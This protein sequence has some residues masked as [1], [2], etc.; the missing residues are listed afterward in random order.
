MD[1]L[2]YRENDRF[3]PIPEN[4]KNLPFVIAKHFIDI[5]V[6]PDGIN[7]LE[8][9]CFDRNGDLFICNTPQG[10]IYKLNVKTK[11][12]KLF[13]ELPNHM[14]P[15]AIKIHK[16]GRI[17][18]T[19]AGSDNGCLILILSE[20]G[21]ILDEIIT[22]TNKMI[23]D[24]VFDTDGGFY[25]TDLGGTMSNKT[26]GVFYVSPDYKSV[27]P[28]IE[29]GMIASNGIVLDSSGRNLWVSEYGA[30]K[31]H[32]MS[33]KEDHYT[34]EPASS[35][36]AYNFVGLEGPDSMSMDEDENIYVAICGQARYMVF[37]S[38]GFPISQILLPERE[39]G[40]MAKSTHLVIDPFTNI[41]YMCSADLNENKCAIY[42]AEVY[43]KSYKF[44]S[45][46][47]G[48]N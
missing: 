11:E 39:K 47:I 5:P 32:R 18:A 22:G 9:L 31:L 28:V 42:T 27:Y 6:N 13:V 16:D 41:A 12:L 26:A 15:S 1:K 24:M 25:F 29:K 19:I 35:Y 46:S 48:G 7:I 8:G 37:N 45:I 44:F 34:I 40:K 21:E 3:F 30:G 33:L 10:K 23:D 20:K 14:M 38:N 17:F 2:T 4:E 36:V 43:A